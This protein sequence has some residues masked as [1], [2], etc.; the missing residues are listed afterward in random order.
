[1]LLLKD[2]IKFVS[3]IMTTKTSGREGSVWKKKK[4]NI[5]RGKFI[6]PV[7]GKTLSVISHIQISHITPNSLGS[8]PFWAL[9]EQIA[10]SHII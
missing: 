4:N 10:I 3:I 6:P 9:A 2:A 8:M 1:M 5:Q 7:F